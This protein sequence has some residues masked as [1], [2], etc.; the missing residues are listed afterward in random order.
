MFY[1]I[2][3]TGYFGGVAKVSRHP[4]YRDFFVEDDGLDWFYTFSNMDG[5]K[6]YLLSNNLAIEDR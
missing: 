4:M 3:S 1:K 2:T 5:E 6:C